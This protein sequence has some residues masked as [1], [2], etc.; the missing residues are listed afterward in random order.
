ME[1]TLNRG[2]SHHEIV[3][4][5]LVAQAVAEALNDGLEQGFC[6]GGTAPCSQ[7]CSISYSKSDSIF[8]PATQAY[9]AADVAPHRYVQGKKQMLHESTV[10][11]LHLEHRSKKAASTACGTSYASKPQHRSGRR[12]GR[13]GAVKNTRHTG[14]QYPPRQL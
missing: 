3:N 9:C 4:E 1:E 5:D 10:Q 6:P 8:D 12:S 13:P 2:D 7:K 11:C 14:S